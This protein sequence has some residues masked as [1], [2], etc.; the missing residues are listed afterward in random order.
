[1]YDTNNDGILREN[2]LRNVLKP[3]MVV[4]GMECLLLTMQHLFIDFHLPSKRCGT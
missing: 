3:V 2:D 1:M 4:N